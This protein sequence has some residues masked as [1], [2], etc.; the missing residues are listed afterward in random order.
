MLRLIYCRYHFYLR[1]TSLWFYGFVYLMMQSFV[2]MLLLQ[3]TAVL[4]GTQTMGVFWAITTFANFGML[5]QIITKQ[6][7]VWL[8]EAGGIQIG[9]PSVWLADFAGFVLVYAMVFLTILPFLS[10]FYGLSVYGSLWLFLIWCVSMPVCL[11]QMYLA[12]CVSL[13]IRG[14]VLLSMVCVMPWVV[15]GLLLVVRCFDRQMAGV[16]M[17]RALCLLL[18]VN[19]VLGA[20]LYWVIAQVLPRCYQHLRLLR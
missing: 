16:E 15:P 5:A 2:F 13:F 6:R 18:G 7:V 8:V 17:V 3:P 19:M 1:Q 12:R 20:L 11:L 14:G 4:S 9:G 10:M